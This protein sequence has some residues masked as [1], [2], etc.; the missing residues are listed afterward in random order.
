MDMKAIH[1]AIEALEM[2]SSHHQGSVWRVRKKENDHIVT[3]YPEK[4]ANE[5]LESLREAINQAPAAW[6]ASNAVGKK[7]MRLTKPDDVYK[8]EP[9]YKIT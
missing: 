4:V 7:F 3:I 1:Q 2:F 5:A 6:I 8:P 9:L